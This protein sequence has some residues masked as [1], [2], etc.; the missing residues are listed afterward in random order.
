[1]A[2]CYGKGFPSYAKKA[3]KECSGRTPLV[4]NLDTG[5]RSVVIFKPL[6]LCPLERNR[7]PLDTNRWSP[8]VDLEV[9]KKKHILQRP[10]YQPVLLII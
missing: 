6:P 2:A 5:G 3:Y 8:R 10:W 9:F 1:V 4:I 7:L